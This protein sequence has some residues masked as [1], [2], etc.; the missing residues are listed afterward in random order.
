MENLYQRTC[1]QFGQVYHLVKYQLHLRHHN[2][3]KSLFKHT[4][5][6]GRS[7]SEFLSSDKIKFTSLKENLPK[8]QWKSLVHLSYFIIEDTLYVQSQQHLNGA[9]LFPVKIFKDLNFETYHCGMKCTISNISKNRVMAVHAWSVFEKIIRY[10][11]RW[12]LMTKS[13]FFR[14]ILVQWYLQLGR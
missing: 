1:L 12:K 11:K 13:V 8:S 6:A 10:L 7:L 5:H 9:P 3:Q 4:Q 14:S 2:T